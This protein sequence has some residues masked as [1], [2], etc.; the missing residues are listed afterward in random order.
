V[1]QEFAKAAAAK[2]GKKQN[3]AVELLIMN[4]WYIYNKKYRYEIC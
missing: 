1:S 3:N 2:K 4:Y